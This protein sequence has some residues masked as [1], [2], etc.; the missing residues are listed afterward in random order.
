M[1]AMIGKTFGLGRIGAILGVLELG[2]SIG[3]GMGPVIGGLI[4]DLRQ[5][6][7][8]SFLVGVVVMLVAAALVVFVRQETD[9][10]IAGR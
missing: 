10:V 5:S 1:A 7:F 3:A 2:F 9:R 4:F 8:L 6:Y